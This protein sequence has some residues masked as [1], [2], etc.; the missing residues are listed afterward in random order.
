MPPDTASPPATPGQGFVAGRS[1]APGTV[2]GASFPPNLETTTMS[3]N[4][5]R[6][7]L[8][9]AVV[10]LCLTGNFTPALLLCPFLSLALVA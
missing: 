9:I 8:G 3:K 5:L 4:T 2:P 10:G 6:W 7:T 1:N